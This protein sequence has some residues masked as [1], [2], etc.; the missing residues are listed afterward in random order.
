MRIVNIGIY[1]GIIV[2]LILWYVHR[3]Q[4]WTNPIGKAADAYRVLV[5]IVLITN[6]ISFAMTFTKPAGDQV[7]RRQDY[8]G[9][10]TDIML[11]LKKEDQTEEY[12]LRV[13]PR[14]YDKATAEQLM[15]KAFEELEQHMKGENASCEQVTSQLC[16]TLDHEKYPFDLTVQPEDYS[17]LDEEGRIHNREEELVAAGFDKEEIEQGIS[18]A[19]KIILSY[20]D[21]TREKTY[22][23]TIVLQEQE[24]LERTF[25]L[26]K[27]ELEKL[28]QD[29]MFDENFLLPEQME[30]VQIIRIDTQR[31]QPVHIWLLGLFAMILVIVGRREKL[32]QRKQERQKRLLRSYPWFVNEMVLM[33]G[34]GMQVKHIFAQLLSEYE[35]TKEK[36]D[37]EPLIRELEAADQAF[38]LGM[39]EEQIYYQLGRRLELSCY[40]KLMTLLEQNVVRGSRGMK[41]IFEQEEQAALEERKNLAK[42]LGEEAGTK[43]L[44]PMIVL[45]LIVMF[46]ILIPAF[47]SF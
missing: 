30:G 29:Q 43:L 41:E 14:Q 9:E 12:Q 47:M 26:V 1:A 39:P 28:E 21:I 33:L 10:E 18:T 17:L 19:V 31:I 24:P 38:Q 7:V 16:F 3:R 36:D 6:S 2:V 15:D 8:A 23:L 11:Q 35:N 4:I 13:K 20:G 45:L 32:R 46:M 44:G 34:A 25:T 40:I 27:K 22:P 5:G 42:R 37:R